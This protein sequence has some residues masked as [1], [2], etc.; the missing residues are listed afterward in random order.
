MRSII[1]LRHKSHGLEILD[2]LANI[3][4]KKVEVGVSEPDAVKDVAVS[5]ILYLLLLLLQDFIL[6]GEL[7][8]LPGKVFFLPF[9]QLIG[10]LEVYLTRASLLAALSSSRSSFFSALLLSVSS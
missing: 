1:C 6:L 4:A 9:E 2:K 10:V 3:W 5:F 7:L 8:I